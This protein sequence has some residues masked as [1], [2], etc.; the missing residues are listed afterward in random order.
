MMPPGKVNFF[1]FIKGR[2][3][4]FVV[5]LHPSSFLE[6]SVSLIDAGRQN[7]W[8]VTESISVIFIRTLGLSILHATD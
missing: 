8:V 6:S 4:T 3:L 2:Y 5:I 7:K 1:V